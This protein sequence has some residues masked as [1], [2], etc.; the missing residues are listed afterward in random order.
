VE[1]ETDEAGRPIKRQVTLFRGTGNTIN[2]APLDEAL[3]LDGRFDNLEDQARGAVHAHYDNMEEPTDKDLQRLAQFQHTRQFF[4]SDELYEF[5]NGG[6]APVLP[7]GNTPEEIRG[8]TFF[9]EKALCGRCHSGPMLN[10]RSPFN[11]SGPGGR[12]DQV[13]V[14]ARDMTV[15]DEPVAPRFWRVLNAQ[16]RFVLRNY[17]D[18]GHML[19]SGRINHFGQFRIPSLWNVKNTAPYFHNNSAANLD[20]LLRHYQEFFEKHHPF[21]RVGVKPGPADLLD[22]DELAAIKAFLLIL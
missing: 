19:Q 11:A 8:R 15:L 5:D 6:P 1:P 16:G 20:V 9:E 22:D 7:P 14:N 21:L 3:M 17:H 2:T 13:Q 18:A 10:R 12:F 4:S